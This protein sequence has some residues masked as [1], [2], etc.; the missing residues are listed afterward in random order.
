M[1]LTSQ[2][3]NQLQALLEMQTLNTVILASIKV[4]NWWVAV[5]ELQFN[6]FF[7]LVLYLFLRYCTSKKNYINARLRSL[8]KEM[9]KR[10]VGVQQL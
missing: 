6:T 2:I 8:K 4:T 1:A 9:K 5:Q 3:G 7:K 10:E